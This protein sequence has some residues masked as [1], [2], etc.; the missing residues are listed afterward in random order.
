MLVVWGNPPEIAR[1]I[2]VPWTDALCLGPN[3]FPIRVE[4]VK[5]FS[6]PSTAHWYPTEGADKTVIASGERKTV[7][8]AFVHRTEHVET[9]A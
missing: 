5:P 1:K 9:K 3:V 8:D 4:D 7:L 2:R 6:L